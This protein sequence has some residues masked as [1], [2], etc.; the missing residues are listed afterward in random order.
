LFYSNF[1]F[2]EDDL[3]EYLVQVDYT[4]ESSTEFPLFHLW[5]TNQAEYFSI[6]DY[7]CTNNILTLF[8]F[9]KLPFQKCTPF[10]M[11]KAQKFP[12]QSSRD[13]FSFSCNVTHTV[14]QRLLQWLSLTKPSLTVYQ[15]AS[16]HLCFVSTNNL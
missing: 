8:G 12:L 16:N 7:T 1:C 13:P 11:E 15:H 10:K 6:H 9:A 4:L 2:A 3:N 14:H 5:L